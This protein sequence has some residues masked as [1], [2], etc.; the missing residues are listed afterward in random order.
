MTDVKRPVAHVSCRF[1]KQA[2]LRVP[3]EFQRVY[4]Q[5]RQLHSSLFTIFVAPNRLGRTRLGITTSRKVSKS[6][7]VRNRC[8]RRLREVFRQQQATLP[9]GWD[10]VV[11]AKFQLTT[12]SYALIKQ[13]FTRLMEKLSKLAE[14]SSMRLADDADV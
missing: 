3:R 9:V 7:V 13:E 10:I 12:A 1:T 11:N 2:R 8:R 5:G 6:A 4:R 14:G